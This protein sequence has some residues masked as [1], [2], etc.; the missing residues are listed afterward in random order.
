MT[1]R[2]G[3]K[4][5]VPCMR[6]RFVFGG[7]GMLGPGWALADEFLESARFTVHGGLPGGPEP[8][9]CRP[10]ASCAQQRAF[11]GMLFHAVQR[12]SHFLRK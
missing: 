6:L 3:C 4:N 1:D 10:Y 5:A 2:P 9:H 8:N 7:N 12:L 11:S